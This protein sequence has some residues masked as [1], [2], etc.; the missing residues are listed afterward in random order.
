ML[1]SP[2]EVADAIQ[3]RKDAFKLSEFHNVTKRGRADYFISH[4]WS[5]PAYVKLPAL[6]S[7]IARS[8]FYTPWRQERFIWLDKYCIDQEAVVDGI[9]LLPI[10]VAACD[11]I[12]IFH[13]ASYLKR[14]W[15]VWELFTLFTFR[16]K[17]LAI[18]RV[19][20]VDISGGV[21]YKVIGADGFDI[22]DA[23]AFD[24][25]EE[26]KLRCI[27]HEI[28]LDRVNAC[29]KYFIEESEVFAPLTTLRRVR[30]L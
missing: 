16:N 3:I 2:R 10:H 22:D 26:F 27:M 21:P 23:H 12:L 18:E 7:F 13:S 25:N 19:A 30:S 15:C 14:L 29:V 4:S 8:I 28:G 5:D 20:V 24:P 9:A 1:K 11:K 17:E 6:R